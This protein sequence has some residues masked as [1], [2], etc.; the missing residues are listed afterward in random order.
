MHESFAV[1]HRLASAGQRRQALA[2][3][4][5]EPLDGR[6]VDHPVTMRASPARLDACRRAIHHAALDVD[7]ASLG[8]ALY[9]LRDADVA[10]RTQPGAPQPP[11]YTGS[12]KV[13]R[14][15]RI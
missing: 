15:A 1:G 6:R 11:I 3:R 10:P 9:D 5:G 8:V 12:R 2:E 7:D 4:R 14:I 13:A